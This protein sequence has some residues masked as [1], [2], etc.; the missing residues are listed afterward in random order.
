M[1]DAHITVVESTRSVTA[2]VIPAAKAHHTKAGTTKIQTP[3]TST[4]DINR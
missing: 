1:P 2:E 3:T 4:A